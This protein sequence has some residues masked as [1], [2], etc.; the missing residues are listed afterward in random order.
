R[1]RFRLPWADLM[2]GIVDLQMLK[3]LEAFLDK[4][5]G[6]ELEQLKRWLQRQETSILHAME[7]TRRISVD[8]QPYWRD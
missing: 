1:N 2:Q 4:L 8:T 7:Q 5:E 3:Q 6:E